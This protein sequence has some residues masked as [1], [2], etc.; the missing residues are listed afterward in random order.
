MRKINGSVSLLSLLLLFT[1]LCVAQSVRR[2]ATS[3]Q[4]PTMVA[5]LT[6][7]DIPRNIPE[8]A[9]YTPPSSGLFRLTIYGTT[10]VPS[11]SEGCWNVSFLWTDETG[12]QFVGMTNLFSPRDL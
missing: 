12:P 10:T 3:I 5:N 8:R 11:Q 6:L 7:L 4:A 9:I 2:K 1:G